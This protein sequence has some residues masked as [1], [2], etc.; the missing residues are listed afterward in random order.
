MAYAIMRTAK[1]KS[2]GAISTCDK[3]NNRE[4]ETPNADE[5]MFEENIILIG[6]PEK[7]YLE[8]FQEMTKDMTIRKNAVYGIECFMSASKEAELWKDERL[9]KEW[10][11]DSIEW[12]KETF[13]EKNIVKV[14]LH[15]DETT[16]HIHAFIVPIYQGKLN[17]KKYLGGHKSRLSDLQTEY[18]EK[19]KKY[20]LERGREGS[21]AKH[22]DV[23][24]Y[25]AS[26]NKE[27]ARELPKPSF[28]E[29]KETYKKRANEEYK[30]VV[31][32]NLDKDMKIERLNELIPTRKS[33]AQSLKEAE[34]EMDNMELINFLDKN[35]NIKDQ[36]RE[37]IQKS[38]DKPRTKKKNKNIER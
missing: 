23:K 37:F 30:K 24:K 16:P 35:P 34:K 15:R 25:Y 6:E 26:L 31:L 12:L 13:D 2:T 9:I 10:T 3:H 22:Q 5:M 7:S 19:V 1:L 8:D 32:Q 4:R 20:G 29:T 33:V 17:C 21:K 28:F 38:K 18:H 14:H 11:K 27:I 36:I